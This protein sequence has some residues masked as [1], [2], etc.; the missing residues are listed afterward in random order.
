[1]GDGVGRAPVDDDVRKPPQVRSQAPV[2]NLRELEGQQP[3][4]VVGHVTGRPVNCG[5]R[6]AIHNAK[7]GSTQ[8]PDALIYFDRT[9]G[10][11]IGW[12]DSKIWWD[13]AKDAMT[14]MVM[15]KLGGV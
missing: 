3:A 14:K 8:S 12:P 9:V 6:V 13:Q 5:D 7:A 11:D 1:M 15:A 10:G 4:D 2:T